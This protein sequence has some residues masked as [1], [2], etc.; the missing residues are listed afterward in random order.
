MLKALQESIW[1]RIYT[2]TKYFKLDEPFLAVLPWLGINKD[3]FFYYIPF[4]VIYTF[5]NAVALALILFFVVV[6]IHIV[7][8]MVLKR[9]T[10]FL[11]VLRNCVSLEMFSGNSFKQ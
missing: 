6:I 4:S 5:K 2:F 10:C 8:Q 11:N 3:Y 9:I 7:D 1:S